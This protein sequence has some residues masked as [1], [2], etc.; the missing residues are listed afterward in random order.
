VEG[1]VLRG[2]AYLARREFVP[3]REQVRIAIARAP[4]ALPPRLI[5]SHVL[6]QEGRDWQAAERAL[7]EVLALDPNHRE[8]QHNLRLLRREHGSHVNGC[9]AKGTMS[10]AGRAKVSLCMIVRNE[11]HNLAACLQSV[12]DL[13]DEMIV[14]DTGSTDRTKEIAH[15]YGARVFDFPW[16]D[17][18]AAARNESLKH[19]TGEWIFWLDADDR[20][21][22]VNRERLRRLFAGLQADNAAYVMK[23]LCLPDAKGV[24]TAVDHLRLFRNHPQ[25]RWQFRVHEQILLAVRAQKGEVRWSDVVIH[26]TGY[27]DAALRGR[28]LERDLRLLQ[29]EQAEQPEHAFTLF[30]LASVYQEMGRKAEALEMFRRSLERSAP[31][32]SI[33]RKLY[34]SIA[35]C[36][37][38]LGQHQEAL[39]VCGAGRK[40]YPDDVE[41][42][43]QEGLA[44]NELEDA[45]GAIACW[46]QCLQVP[47]GQHFSSVN[48]GL[49]GYITRQNLAVA[50]RKVGRLSE[51]EEHWRATLA[52]QP[53]Y[54]PA[55]RGLLEL[56]LKG[57]RWA[58]GEELARQL[59]VGPQGPVRV[60]VIRSRLHLARKEFDAA[61]KLLESA[62][63]QYPQEVE[64]RVLLSHV[65]LQE[66]RDWPAAQRAL[67]DVLA[68]D[69]GHTESRH[70]LA[71]LLHEQDPASNG[72]V[73][74]C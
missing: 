48:T 56:Y 34:A 70:N 24:S 53:G 16:V 65:L 71:V 26:H 10:A 4:Q 1:L 19:A 44:R 14:V 40:H 62:I 38:D 74:P 60:V 20:L 43:F 52:E 28:K 29:L 61:G 6:L 42:L 7:L 68:L 63:E 33:V 36:H 15:R 27:Q 25:V 12:G 41:I 23:C 49:R 30:N 39:D 8:A 57:Q 35:Q 2:R 54:E 11:E 5:L 67:C 32:D 47:K 73:A 18:F 22:E 17:H 51:A 46:E 55:W 69:P 9:Q 59:D 3:A 13:V 31:E 58:E 45:A 66:G 64:L 21:D 72:T 37:R 50:L